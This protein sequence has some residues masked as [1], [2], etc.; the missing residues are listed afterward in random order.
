MRFPLYKG[1]IQDKGRW[2]FACGRD[3]THALRIPDG[4]TFGVC[5]DHLRLVNSVHA[6]GLP[7]PP[8]LTVLGPERPKPKSLAAA[9]AEVE[10]HF[11]QKGQ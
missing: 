5:P 10:N 3:A 7:T 4:T 9:I 8:E 1:P 2:C 6:V 11:Q